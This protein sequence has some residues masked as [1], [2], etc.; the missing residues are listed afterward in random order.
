MG[1]SETAARFTA[2]M[3]TASGLCR[4][5]DLRAAGGERLLLGALVAAGPP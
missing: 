4:F 2:T 3:E 5:V 1:S